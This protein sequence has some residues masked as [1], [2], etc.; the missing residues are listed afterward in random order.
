MSAENGAHVFL[1]F[2]KLF[3]KY[4]RHHLLIHLHQFR[5]ITF[6]RSVFNRKYILPKKFAVIEKPMAKQT[7]TK[8]GNKY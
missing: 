6:L 2:N 5:N 8:L 7:L 1:F 3:S 4:L